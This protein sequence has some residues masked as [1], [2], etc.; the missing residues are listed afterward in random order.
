MIKAKLVID[1]EYELDVI[2]FSMGLFRKADE[3]GKPTQNAV[4][5]S[6]SVVVEANPKVDFMYWMLSPVLRKQVELHVYPRTID[7]RLR[8][9][10]F[11]DVNLVGFDSFFSSTG[12]QPLI[13]ELRFTAA[14]LNT[15]YS[16]VEYSASWRQTFLNQNITPATIPEPE[17]PRIIRQYITDENE[18]ELHSY[19][20]GDNILYIIESEG[21][22]GKT[23][24]VS[25]PDKTVD[26]LYLD[27][28]L[29]NDTIE[30]YTIHSDIEKIPLQV[31]PEDYKD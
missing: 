4:L 11:S 1:K 14:G 9:F 31:I 10:Y 7:K 18:V 21:F 28:R 17:E 12:E 26:F 16:T 15:N 6:L 29:K 27:K 13:D 30:A 8:I 3:T 25:I 23:I 20:Q 19:K 24:K 22:I 2:R 5:N